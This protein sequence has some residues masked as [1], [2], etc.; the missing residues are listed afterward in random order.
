MTFGSK[1]DE[2]KWALL[3]KRQLL[4]MK[5]VEQNISHGQ[6]LSSCPTDVETQGVDVWVLI[7]VPESYPR[8][9]IGI[10]RLVL[11]QQIHEAGIGCEGLPVDPRGVYMVETNQRRATNECSTYTRGHTDSTY[12][13]TT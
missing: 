10:C 1:P 12:A 3:R 11:K 5:R 9:N 2:E 6:L 13:T 4:T 7:Q 8:Q